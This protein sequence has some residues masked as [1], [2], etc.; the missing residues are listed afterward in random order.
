ML[1]FSKLF[2]CSSVRSGT[3]AG[4]ISKLQRTQNF[5]ARIINGAKKLD[6]ITPILKTLGW[7]PVK[8]LYDKSRIK[9]FDVKVN[10]KRGGLKGDDK[11]RW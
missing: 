10:Y 6:H 5:A 4:H 9:L 8:K 7:L 11:S 3:S 2:Y 1:V